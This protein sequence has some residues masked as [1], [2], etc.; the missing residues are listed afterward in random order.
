VPRPCSP[1][2]AFAVAVLFVGGLVQTV[3]AQDDVPAA[4]RRFEVRGERPFLGGK[5]ID[6]WGIRCGNALMD[7]AVTERHIRCLDN[8]IAHGINCIGVYI[9][10]SNPGW[11]DLNASKNGYTADGNLKPA[12]ARRVEHLVREADR[13]GM[14]VMV[15]LISPRKD[16][17]LADEAAVKHAIE[18]T[19]RFLAER[20]LQNVFVD[21]YHEFNSERADHAIFREP[22]GQ[23]KKAMLT[24]WFK[25]V[26][27]GVPVG[28]TPDFKSKAS[29]LPFPGMDIHLIQKG[30]PIPARGLVVSVETTR[31]DEYDNDGV[32]TPEARKRMVAQWEQYR[33]APNACMLFHSAFTQGITNKSASAPHPEMGGYGTGPDD[34]GVR[35][36]FDW[37]KDNIGPYHYPNH[38]K[39]RR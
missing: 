16:Q 5:Q 1:V 36:Y 8:F 14:V 6:L 28:I 24:A 25:K 39:G 33:A 37:V 18:A 17:E 4:T 35:F 9:Q 10:G 20:K 11:P 29:A 32:F 2:T 3:A 19:A 15:G 31:E 13:R 27:P 26:N 21:L 23:A 22:D 30:Y 12:F 34:R 38:A 7:D